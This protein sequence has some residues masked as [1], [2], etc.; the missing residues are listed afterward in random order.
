MRFDHVAAALS[1]EYATKIRDITLYPP[2]EDAYSTLKDLLIKRTAVSERNGL[3]LLFTSE[4]LGDQ[5]P[6]QLQGGCSNSWGT[7]LV[8]QR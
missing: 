6:D 5:K 8:L 1:N 7:L 3:Q 2:E 4:E